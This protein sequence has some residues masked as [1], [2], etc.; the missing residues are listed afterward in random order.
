MSSQYKFYRDMKIFDGDMNF[1]PVT[2]LLDTGCTKGI[3]ISQKKVESL[4]KLSQIRPIVEPTMMRDGSGRTFTPCGRITIFF[5]WIPNGRRTHQ[6]EFYVFDSDHLD[7]ILGGEYIVAHHLAEI[8]E[9]NFTPLT[10]HKKEDIGK[11]FC[12]MFLLIPWAFL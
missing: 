7:V 1:I 8:N 2:A 10:E 3:W 6:E 5:K 9:G 12:W 11:L 4:G